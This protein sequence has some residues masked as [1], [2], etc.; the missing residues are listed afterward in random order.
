MVRA[1]PWPKGDGLL[2]WRAKGSRVPFIGT[3]WCKRF[4]SAKNETR[5]GQR[6]WAPV[7]Q[8]GRGCL[9]SGQGG[10]AQFH[11][12]SAGLLPTAALCGCTG[13]SAK[14]PGRLPAAPARNHRS[15]HG[16]HSPHY[17][18]ADDPP[19]VQPAAA[20]G[21]AAATAANPCGLSDCQF[22][23]SR[24]MQARSRSARQPKRACA[25]RGSA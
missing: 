12:P 5:K 9:Q 17:R 8:P 7:Q 14:N 20:P 25:W 6:C 2:Q 3:F 22:Q 15:L 10:S 11:L 4:W 19:A 13:R 23:A 16:V 24:H 21:V 18:P 1:E